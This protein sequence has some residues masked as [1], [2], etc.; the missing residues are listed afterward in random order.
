MVS[1]Q[2]QGAVV[3]TIG[4]FL[5]AK[6]LKARAVAFGCWLLFAAMMFFD[7]P[8]FHGGWRIVPFIGFLGSVLYILWCVNCPKCEARLGQLMS[9]TS[10]PNFCPGCGVSFDTRV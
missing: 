9:G 8:I 5:K 7:I 6:M 3:M 1:G 10:K 4:E 2:V